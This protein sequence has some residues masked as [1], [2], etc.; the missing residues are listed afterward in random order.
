ML[1]AGAGAVVIVSLVAV[2]EWRVR[3]DQGE[4]SRL[5]KAVGATLPFDARLSGG[6]LP[7]AQD[8]RRSTMPAPTA[9][10][11][12]ARIAIAQIEKRAAADRTS[13]ALGDVGVAYLVEGDVD[14]AIG[15][16]EEAT[17]IG[18]DAAQWSDLSAA[19]L[20]KSD[21]TPGRRIEYIARALETSTRSLRLRP[22]SEGRFNQSI[23]LEALAPYVGVANPWV[24]YLRDERDARWQAVAREHQRQ[25]RTK[26]DPRQAWERRKAALRE[27]LDRSERAAIDETAAQ[28]P[29]ATIEFFERELLVEWARVVLTH[30]GARAGTVLASA[31]V[32]AAAIQRS[33]GD[34]IQTRT[35]DA[36][37]ASGTP[38]D[39]ARAHLAYVD[40]IAR[41]DAGDYKASRTSFDA[42]LAGFTRVKSPYAEWASL[43]IAVILFQQRQL[44]EAADRLAIVEHNAR[45]NGFVT[46]RG[47]AL[48]MRGLTQSKQWRL[49][50]AM[51]GFREASAVYSA[52]GEWENRA[53]VDSVIAANLR[54][55][56][57]Y[58]DSWAY[59]AQTLEA[60]G[61]LRKPTQRY[62]ILFN[63]SL[64][65]SSQDLL[66]A[67]L[68]F[69]DAAVREAQTAGEAQL[70]EALTQR[71]T[72]FIHQGRP[73]EA[74][75][76]LEAARAK[77][78][79][80][81]S[82]ALLKY[83]KAELDVLLADLAPSQGHPPPIDDLRGAVS[84][85]SVAE[86]AIVPRLQLGLARAQ[87][88]VHDHLQAEEAFARGI[89]LLERQREQLGDEAL[90]V[91]YFD[92]SWNL[93]SEMIEFQSRDRHDA[94]RAFEFAERSRARSLLTG[95]PL[96]LAEIQRSLPDAAVMIYYATLS[97][98]V[99]VWTVTNSGSRLVEQKVSRDHLGRLVSRYLTEVAATQ[100]QSRT[101]R[102]LSDLLIQPIA[103]QLPPGAL[104]IL[105]PDGELQRVPF[106]TLKTAETAR[107]LVEDHPILMSPS[108]TFY[109]T[110]L[111]RSKRLSVTQVR[112]GLLVGDPEP[113]PTSS[114]PHLPGA[115]AEANAAAAFYAEH[116]VLTGP[117]ATKE[118]FLDLAPRFD[119]VHF[120][121]HALANAEFPQLSRL[122][123]AAARGGDEPE[124]LY[125]Y[126]VA[127]LQLPQTRLVVLAACSTAVG[128]VSH[129][130]GVV[131]V[132]RPFLAAG[133]PTVVASQWDIDDRVAQLL[134]VAFHREFVRTQDA[135]LSLQ[136]AQ[137][138]LLRSGKA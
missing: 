37:A 2:R 75:G 21:R 118:R 1:A 71:A 10:S 113:A 24:E 136:R 73:G 47:R 79:A 80:V 106:A 15:A 108:G 133:V 135:A 132:A 84:F 27:A 101:A 44:N 87:L 50:D 6:F 5:A 49:S 4:L 61:H 31:R 28:F 26:P 13:P 95:S 3:R 98:R 77:L 126:E 20:V 70:V 137:V 59:S 78:T 22:T 96:T 129:G 40:G 68:R 120:G 128:A 89:S 100:D 8:V 58:N 65:A 109:A 114:R 90:K 64:F 51:S 38:D 23:A 45:G 30:N 124:P 93:F 42:A 19:Y 123:F 107:Y 66:E 34:S 46:L 99:L 41:Y 104:L 94:V 130:E 121:G 97:D 7:P 134:F 48:W 60:L 62:L 111:A 14:K 117:S 29:E 82:E 103:S 85:F 74:N 125:A 54:M 110:A 17:S 115:E 102:Q 35:L 52:A 33:T 76:D 112:S 55:L 18:D 56:G 69:Q 57:E 91:S 12:D 138:D 92:E 116:Q 72:I 131:S 122:L 16:L 11:P 36:I 105:V 81:R 83:L 88:A 32:I 119:V 67:A 53:N 86:P 9:L 39:A 43:E 63:A 25:T 127:G